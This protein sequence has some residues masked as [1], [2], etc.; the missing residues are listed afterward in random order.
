MPAPPP[1]S[2]EE[3]ALRHP[4][5]VR[6]AEVDA[7]GVVFNAHYLLYF[8][9]AVTEYMRALGCLAF[10]SA[11]YLVHA[12]IDYRR[13]ARFDDDLIVGARTVAVGRSSY[14][15]RFAAFR[16]DE[17]LVSATHV[18]VHAIGEPP[19]PAPLPLTFLA[20]VAGLERVAPG[21][22]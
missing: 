19:A 4:L 9:V 20:A 10:S 7:Q 22:A 17:P 21:P 5:R 12:S 1:P 2:L 6:W 16:G 14:H 11:T 13:P 8:D 18:Y 15:M 3:F